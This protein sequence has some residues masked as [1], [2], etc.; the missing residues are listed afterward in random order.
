MTLKAGI[1]EDLLNRVDR[2]LKGLVLGQPAG[3]MENLLALEDIH[4]IVDLGNE[5]G[6]TSAV[7]VW[8]SWCCDCVS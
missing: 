5:E 7:R 8:R 3:F 6:R 4:Q 1:Q 2:V